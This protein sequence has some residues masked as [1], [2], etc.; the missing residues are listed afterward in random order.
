MCIFDIKEMVN[1]I[2]YLPN[3][4]LAMKRNRNLLLVFDKKLFFYML[5][6]VQQLGTL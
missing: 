5:C 1:S 3:E 4:P 6:L 2:Y